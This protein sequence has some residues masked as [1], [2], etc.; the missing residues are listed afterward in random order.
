MK[1]GVL[2]L[3]LH[4]NYGGILQAYA[5][6]QVLTRQ[7]HEAVLIDQEHCFHIPLWKKPLVYAKQ[8]VKKYLL[9]RDIPIVVDKYWKNLWETRTKYTGKFIEKNIARTLVENI[10][11]L[12]ADDFDAIVVGSDQ[13]WRRPYNT[14]FPG[15]EN[16]FLAFAKEWNIKR[17]SYAASFGT[18]DWEYNEEQTAN[19]SELAK[20]F[21]AISVREVSAIDVCKRHLGVEAVHMVDPTM[22]LNSDDYKELFK[23]YDSQASADT[24][25]CYVLDKCEETDN[26]IAEIAKNRNLTPYFTNSRTEDE[27]APLEE[28]VQPPVEEW[29]KSFN[30][31]EFIITDSFHA[32]VFSI[33]FKKPFMVYG[34]KERGYARFSSLLSTFGLE[35]RLITSHKELIEKIDLLNTPINYDKVYEVL[36]NKRKDGYSF[37]ENVLSHTNTKQKP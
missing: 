3:P 7:G 30:D 36:N 27:T 5:L 26:I 15:V 21:D 20:L 19:C 23:D 14:W 10:S 31:A 16:A 8:M 35:E 37:L 28:R 29:L 6:Q 2:T 22:L 32:C 1:I 18:D 34:N 13:I 9:G 24:L 25:M 11:E 33:L 12:K 4:T 17:V